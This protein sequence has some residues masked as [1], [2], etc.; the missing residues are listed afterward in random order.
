MIDEREQYDDK[1]LFY[2]SKYIPDYGDAIETPLTEEDIAS[3]KKKLEEMRLKK[4]T[5]LMKCKNNPFPEI[6]PYN[7]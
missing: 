1:L 3:G 7:K 2:L 6:K 5:M 4:K